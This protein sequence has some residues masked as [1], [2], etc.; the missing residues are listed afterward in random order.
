VCPADLRPVTSHCAVGRQKGPKGP[1]AALSHTQAVLGCLLRTGYV[2]LHPSC[3]SA[4]PKTPVLPARRLIFH[5]CS[6]SSCTV[7]AW[8]NRHLPSTWPSTNSCCWTPAPPPLST[9]L[10]SCWKSTRTAK[11][12]HLTGASLSQTHRTGG[13]PWWPLPARPSAPTAALPDSWP[14]LLSVAG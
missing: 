10:S 7:P 11:G 9:R 13:D 4:V 3:Q 5:C 12:E 8:P 2:G 1:R 6:V 14:G